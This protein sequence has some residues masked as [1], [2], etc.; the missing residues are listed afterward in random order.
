MSNLDSAKA[1]QVW[2]RVESSSSVRQHLSFSWTQLHRLPCGPQQRRVSWLFNGGQPSARRLAATAGRFVHCSFLPPPSI[3]W[4][5]KC[6]PCSSQCCKIRR[7]GIGLTEVNYGYIVTA[8]S[9]AYALGLLVVGGFIDRVGTKLGY[10]IAVAIWG[11][12]AASHALMSF[13]RVVAPLG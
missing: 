4:I 13:P 5:G 10:A 8:F 2:R 6:W 9:L 7:A 11:L 3:T 1:V 12:A